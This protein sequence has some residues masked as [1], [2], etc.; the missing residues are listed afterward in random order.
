MEFSVNATASPKKV[1][2]PEERGRRL[3]MILVSDFYGKWTDGITSFVET[4]NF[5]ESFWRHLGGQTGRVR[6][7]DE[8]LSLLMTVNGIFLLLELIT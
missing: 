7:A 5:T 8:L 4:V 1:Y 2:P 3:R 6:S